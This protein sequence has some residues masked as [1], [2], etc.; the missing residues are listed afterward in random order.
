MRGAVVFPA[1]ARPYPGEVP[2]PVHED[3][4]AV[5]DPGLRPEPAGP[6]PEPGE[7]GCTATT[8]SGEPCKGRP[9]D[10]G[11]CAAHKQD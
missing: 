10:D 1:A 5:P 3:G 11:R 6:E 7:N 4:I 2:V 8:K 9:G